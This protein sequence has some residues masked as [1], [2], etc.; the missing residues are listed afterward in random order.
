MRRFCY[1]S[2][3]G[4]QEGNLPGVEAVLNSVDKVTLQ[5]STLKGTGAGAISTIPTTMENAFKE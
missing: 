1:S 2:Y 4:F 5:G 3:L